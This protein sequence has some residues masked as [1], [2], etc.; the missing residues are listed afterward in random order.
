MRIEVVSTKKTDH[1]KYVPIK[2]DKLSKSSYYINPSELQTE[3]L[4]LVNSY[5][6]EVKS[7][8][9][10]GKTQSTFKDSINNTISKL[11][12]KKI[13]YAQVE[14]MM[15]KNPVEEYDEDDI[16]IEDDNNNEKT[17]DK[18]LS[19]VFVNSISKFI[20]DAN[21]NSDAML[22]ENDIVKVSKIIALEELTFKCGRSARGHISEELGEM[23]LKVAKGIGNK[24]NFINY[25]YKE[26]MMG[27][28]IEFL[29]KYAKK[30][31]YE[32]P[33]ANAFAY[34]SQICKN[35]FI[36]SINKEKK[37]SKMKDTLI[38][39]SMHCSESEKWS[40]ENDSRFSNGND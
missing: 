7:L 25:T 33:K 23:F 4:L 34:L 15:Y 3:M 19:E 31:K 24:K 36:Q 27:L 37:Q 8:I 17:I 40:R 6:E 14:D 39:Q 32:L 38:K 28:G 2:K 29:C 18:S 20:K 1:K 11:T 21:C 13:T 16:L 35:G 30:F 9:K 22:S 12:I 26:E 10:K 5:R